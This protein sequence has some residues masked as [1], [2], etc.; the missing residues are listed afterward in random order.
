VSD[1]W[2]LGVELFGDYCYEFGTRMWISGLHVCRLN[3]HGWV[4]DIHVYRLDPR[5]QV[6]DHH[7]C[8]LKF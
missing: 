2:L 6:L 3:P 1:T 7:V 4:L 5:R 8:H